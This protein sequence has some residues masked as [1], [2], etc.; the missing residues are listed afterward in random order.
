[1]IRGI[2][3]ELERG[4]ILGIAG[5]Q[6]SGLETLELAVT[7]FLPFSGTLRIDRADL[8]GAGR[9]AARRVRKFR[10][11]GGAYLGIR[12]EGTALSIRDL[13]LIHAH[14]HF[15]SRGILEQNRIDH[16]IKAVMAA[17]RVPHREKA[18]SNAFS[19]GQLQ[20]LLLTREMAEH[21]ILLVLSNPGRNLDRRY[22]EK[23][24]VLLRE[25]AGE[26][27]AVLIFSTDVEELV[28]LADSVAV[29]RD[30]VFSGM[31]ELTDQDGFRQNQM[32]HAM[33]MI[34][35]AMVGWA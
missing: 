25:K 17:A 21:G 30:G 6:D 5:V 14:R 13:L 16:W 7:G 19:G 23:L 10:H 28:A 33:G 22:R 15:Q 26:K 20:R 31:V 4:R 32:H 1:L 27:T 29:L 35:E 9:S 3:L 12:N 2:N 34:Q 24:A 18:A 11:A 8:S